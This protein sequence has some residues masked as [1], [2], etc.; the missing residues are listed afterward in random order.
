MTW[1]LCDIVAVNNQDR[2][3]REFPEF[4][5]RDAERLHVA[6]GGFGSR[7]RIENTLSLRKHKVSGFKCDDRLQRLRS[8][9]AGIPSVFPAVRMGDKH[10]GTGLLQ[11]FSH[12]VSHEP[13]IFRSSRLRSGVGCLL[14]EKLVDGS[15]IV[16]ELSDGMA[17]WSFRGLPDS[18]A[19]GIPCGT[20]AHG[21]RD[22]MFDFCCKSA[23]GASAAR[24]VDDVDRPVPAREKRHEPFAP[25]RCGFK[26]ASGLS[27]SM[28][29]DQRIVR[30][31]CGMKNCA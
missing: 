22:R 7:G 15:R 25:V 12:C 8:G 2:N 24:L 31:F 9:H 5:L 20:F 14:T 30:A 29:E 16:R 19:E 17:I 21:C 10:G 11:Q 23:S 28:P 1:L 27:D 13:V 4:R 3:F 6:S 18:V 26:T